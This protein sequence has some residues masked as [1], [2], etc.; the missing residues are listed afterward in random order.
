M[1]EFAAVAAGVSAREPRI[2]LVSNL[3]GQLAGPEYGSVAYWVDHARNPVRFVDGVQLAESLGAGVFLEVGP[4]AALTTAVEQSLTTDRAVSA[5]TMA[6]ARPEVDSLLLAA[7]QL[8]ATGSDVDWAAAFADVNARRV[9]LP[10]YAF[11]RRRFW[12]SND[13]VGSANIASLGLAEAEHALL[14]AVVDR[15][16]SGGVVLTDRKSVV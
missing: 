12:L 4:G 10:T 11:V 9:E 13:S 1:G 5:V 14:G 7:G 2:A 6:K 16:D 3:T 15:P 8:F